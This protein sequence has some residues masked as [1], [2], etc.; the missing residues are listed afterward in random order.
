M[1]RQIHQMK[2]TEPQNNYLKESCW[3]K[4]ASRR[5]SIATEFD[6]FTD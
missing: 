3:E 1:A 4:M 6:N 2:A 5:S